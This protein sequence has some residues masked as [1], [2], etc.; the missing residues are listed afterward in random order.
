MAPLY[1]QR[2]Q[3]RELTAT[4]LPLLFSYHRGA[5]LD[6]SL[7]YQLIPFIR[8]RAD[9][10]SEVNLLW[11]LFHTRSTRDRTEVMLGPL[12][13]SEHHP[14]APASWQILGGLIARDCNYATGT[15]RWYAFWLIPLG[16]R[17]P[18]AHPAPAATS[19]KGS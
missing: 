18:Y 14:G 9:D 19:V 5:A 11:R 16:S 15:Y 17:K 4:V 2:A 7:A 1:Y 3:G 10:G 13:W 8:Q 6:T 12:W